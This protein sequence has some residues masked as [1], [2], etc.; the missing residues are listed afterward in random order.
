MPRCEVLTV[1]TLAE[2]RVKLLRVG[3]TTTFDDDD[4]RCY[5]FP[6]KWELLLE[7]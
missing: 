5:Y 4:G 1:C 3:F 2:E 7:E 6:C